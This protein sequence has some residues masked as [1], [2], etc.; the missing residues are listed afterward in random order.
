MWLIDLR[1]NDVFAF[2][3]GESS[4][5][6]VTIKHPTEEPSQQLS[7]K[8]NR[9]WSYLHISAF[10]NV[11]HKH[12]AALLVKEISYKMGIQMLLMYDR[13]LIAVD[14]VKAII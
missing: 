3:K 7:T 13:L 8:R 1:L 2:A 5:D 12:L 11:L 14:T 10:F 6:I 4:T 9:E